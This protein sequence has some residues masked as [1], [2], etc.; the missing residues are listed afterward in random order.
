[1]E[2]VVLVSWVE[3]GMIEWQYYISSCSFRVFGFWVLMGL[4]R[5]GYGY[6]YGY[7]GSRDCRLHF[8]GV[9]E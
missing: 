8:G 3:I 7:C 2:V 1:M 5:F 6:G 4:V 9:Y